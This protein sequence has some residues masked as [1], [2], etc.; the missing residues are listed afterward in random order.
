MN[1]THLMK[2]TY[3]L[4]NVTH[5]YEFVVNRRVLDILDGLQEDHRV[6]T[7]DPSGF[8]TI[9]TKPDVLFSKFIYLTPEDFREVVILCNFVCGALNSPTRVE[10]KTNGVYKSEEGYV[11]I[12]AY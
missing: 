9:I 11:K 12:L 10:I 1:T 3:D 6:Y 4:H 7:C 5:S 2:L 8:I